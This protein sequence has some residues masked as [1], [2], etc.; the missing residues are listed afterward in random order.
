M[1]NDKW[2]E[3]NGRDIKELYIIF[4]ENLKK[5]G[6]QYKNIDYHQFCELIYFYS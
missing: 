4:K 1:Y 2:L 5:Y 3:E 6:L